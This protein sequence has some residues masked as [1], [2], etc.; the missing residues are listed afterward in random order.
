M[1]RDHLEGVMLPG[2]SY[3]RGPHSGTG[4]S[5]KELFGTCLLLQTTGGEEPKPIRRAQVSLSNRV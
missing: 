1:W 4:H 3:S 2:P 5:V